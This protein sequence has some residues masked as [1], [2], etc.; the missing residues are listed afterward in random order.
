VGIPPFNADHPQQ[1]FDNI[2]NRNIQWPPVPED[3]SHEA[4]DLIDRL[5]TEDPHQRLGA[6]GAA[7]VKQHSFFKDIDWNTLAQQKVNFIY[8]LLLKSYALQ[9]PNS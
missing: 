9:S 8:L 4:R 7:E 5:L 3:M 1:I 6:R 2:L